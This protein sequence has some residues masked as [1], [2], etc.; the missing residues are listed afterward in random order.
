MSDKSGE[1]GDWGRCSHG[2]AGLCAECGLPESV[3][4]LQERYDSG[5]S[6]GVAEERKRAASLLS[7]L[8]FYS[9]KRNHIVMLKPSK[10]MKASSFVLKDKGKRA[11]AALAEYEGEGE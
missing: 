1:M 5:Y 3:T 6:A 9:D 8:E 2:K 11:R 7:A 10:H 4:E